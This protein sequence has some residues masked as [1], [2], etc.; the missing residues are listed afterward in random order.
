[1]RQILDIQNQ[2]KNLSK[3]FDSNELNSLLNFNTEIKTYLQVN[4]KDDF[5]LKLVSEIPDFKLDDFKVG[6]DYIGI[7]IGVFSSSFESF[8]NKKYDF[9]KAKVALNLIKDKYASLEN[10]LM[11]SSNC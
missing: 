9:E 6:F 5:I 8:N 4:I 3:D 10:I 7:L 2:I 11:N 1:M